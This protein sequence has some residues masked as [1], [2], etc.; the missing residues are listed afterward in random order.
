MSGDSISS[1]V[2]SSWPAGAKRWLLLLTSFVLIALATRWL[3]LV[4]D[5]I[6]LDETCH[7][8]G[9]WQLMRGGLLYTD[10]VDNKPPLV[11]AYYAVTQLLAGRSLFAVHLVTAACVIPLTALAVSSCYRHGRVRVVAALM[12][13]LYSAA[14]IGHDM[15][16]TNAEVLMVL[17]SAWAVVL[18][19]DEL[20]VRDWRRVFAAGL[21]FGLSG[22]FK[23]QAG[24]WIVAVVVVLVWHGT[25][26]GRRFEGVRSAA[27]MMA[28]AF[29]PVL[30][31]LAYFRARDG[32]GAFV[33][34]MGVNNLSYAENPITFREGA[35]RFASYLVPF[36]VVTA[37]L[38]IAWWRG[39][40]LLRPAYWRVLVS[41]LVIASLPPAFLG[42][43][44]YP[45]YFIQLYVPLALASAPWLE[46]QLR[47]P[48]TDAGRFVLAWTAVVA[49]GFAIANAMLYLGPFHV[50]RERDPRFRAVAQR[51]RADP[52]ARGG[53]MFVWGWAPMIYYLADMP[54]ATRF[55]VLAPSRLTGYVAG[56]LAS[57]RGEAAEGDVVP[58]HWDWLMDDLKRRRATF[59]IDTAPAN[60]FRWGRYPLRRYP[61][62]MRYVQSE[63]A[64]AG[65]VGGIRIYRRRAC[66]AAASVIGRQR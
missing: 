31:A 59:V 10:F 62:L 22:L 63:F 4:V 9:A 37:P 15:L 52:C 55:V 53:S 16:A 51:V 60:V 3:S 14:F 5:V 19:R 33:Y 44:F 34:W 23:P 46:R 11:Y 54:P 50:Y 13:L 47:R 26:N 35:A 21:L 18:M 29:V 24:T 41:A 64:L 32:L 36:V 38:W 1:T 43:R 6:D 45:H 48:V 56:N 2:R 42:F 27:V 58:Q 25:A 17:P 66:E 40:S 8:V 49:V 65:D 39:R 61:R 30:G 12:F 20:R 57:N 7:I 28:G